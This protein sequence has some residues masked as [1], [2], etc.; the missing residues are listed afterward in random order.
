MFG[1]RLRA[2]SCLKLLIT[3]ITLALLKGF[4]IANAQEQSDEHPPEEKK[5][6]GIASIVFSPD[7][8]L[9]ALVKGN[10]QPGR[11]YGYNAYQYFEGN[12]NYISRIEVWGLSDG[13][14]IRT[15]SDFVGPV[16]SVCFSPDGSYIATTNWELKDS[17]PLPKTALSFL[18]ISCL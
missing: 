11:F 8:R 6:Y 13:K 1:S 7:G 3:C 2:N 18:K 10:L 5:S 14:L 17:R 12:V 15:F 9:V 4:I 16:P